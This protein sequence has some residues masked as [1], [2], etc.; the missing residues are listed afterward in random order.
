MRLHF[1]IVLLLLAL[2]RPASADT[3]QEMLSACRPIAQS[4]VVGDYARFPQNYRTGYCWGVFTSIQQII[5]HIDEN[6]RR[7]Y[8]I[9]S[10]PEVRL[11]QIVAVFVTFAEKNPQRLH[12]DFFPFALESLRSA[13]PCSV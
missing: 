3:V 11:T 4:E 8:F 2:A 10:P 13:F 1:L 9:C 5:V 7:V 6:R 12:E